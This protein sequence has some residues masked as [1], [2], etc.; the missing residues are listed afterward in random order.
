[1]EF[2]ETREELL[3][4]QRI[5]VSAL[6]KELTDYLVELRANMLMTRGDRLI[7]RLSGTDL[8]VAEQI[9]VLKSLLFAGNHSSTILQTNAAWLLATNPEQ[10]RLLADD[11]TLLDR[12]LDEVLRYKGTFR[13]ITR[14]AVKDGD[15]QGTPFY[16]GD[17]LIAWLTSASR[18][19]QVFQNPDTF[20]IT[21][22][23][24]RHIAFG[25]GPHHC[26]GA[27]LAKL[28]LRTVVQLLSK[29]RDI[30]VLAEP[31]PIADP[32]VDGFQH[33]Q[34]TLLC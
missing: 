3:N 17:Y 16:K 31:T 33:L 6:H 18:D 9:G 28:E 30:R 26:I 15:I 23:P 2:L 19:T 12:A 11:H 5:C 21:R 13:G 32:W 24:N 34:V 14:M 1:L 25:H 4:E 27:N 29:V 8:T 22:F 7:H 10:R 20:D